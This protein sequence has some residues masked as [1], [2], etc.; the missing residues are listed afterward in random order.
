MG[1]V[2]FAVSFYAGW[3]HSLDNEGHRKLPPWI[4]PSAPAPAAWRYSPHWRGG[5]PYDTTRSPLSRSSKL[6]SLGNGRLATGAALP[7]RRGTIGL[8]F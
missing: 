7:R 4:N 1:S 2:N 6:R 8:D 5:R 3:P